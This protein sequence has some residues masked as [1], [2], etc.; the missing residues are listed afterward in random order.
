MGVVTDRL[1]AFYVRVAVVPFL[2]LSARYFRYRSKPGR[3]KERLLRATE[4]VPSCFQAHLRLGALYLTEND[5]YH[6]KREFLLARELNP[7]K[8][9]RL[10]PLVT[11]ATGD[12]NINLFYFPGYTDR[13][14]AADAPADFLREFI[15]DPVEE[16]EPEEG[17]RFG[18][19]ASYRE[20]RRFQEMG[21][22]RADEIEAVD[23]DELA[24]Q[25]SEEE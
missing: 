24:R 14:Q 21:P 7:G 12:V 3:A 10:Y 16:A 20:F 25:L 2:L 15:G 18:D 23:W 5:F 6:A 9:R 13:E 11:G 8:F 4:L 19:F 22:F 1:R 17:I